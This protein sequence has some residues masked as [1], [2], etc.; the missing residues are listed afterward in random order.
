MRF[1]RLCAKFIDLVDDEEKSFKAASSGMTFADLLA[2]HAASGVPK[3]GA[4]RRGNAKAKGQDVA[5]RR[6]RNGDTGTAET[7]GLPSQHLNTGTF[8]G[9]FA[10]TISPVCS[11]TALGP[12]DQFWVCANHRC[13]WPTSRA[14]W[15]DLLVL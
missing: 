14:C 10:K 2:Q 3:P 8:W 15:G 6:S 13:S 1:P 7:R 11:W 9:W 4:K 12:H 5:S